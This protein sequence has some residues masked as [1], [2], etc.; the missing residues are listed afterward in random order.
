MVWNE[1]LQRSG[2]DTSSWSSKEP[3][4]VVRHKITSVTLCFRKQSSRV[5][6]PGRI[7]RAQAGGKDDAEVQQR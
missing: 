1:G 7:Q 3:V 4:M 6:G 5:G 2:A